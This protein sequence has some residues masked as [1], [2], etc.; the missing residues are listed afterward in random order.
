MCNTYYLTLFAAVL[1]MAC[2]VPTIGAASK[3]PP[4]A[5]GPQ[6]FAQVAQPFVEHNC[7]TCHG[8]KKAKAGFRI[9]L[10]GADFSAPKAAEQWKEVIDRINAGEM[11]PDGKT[12]PDARQSAAFVGWVNGQLHEVDLAAKKTGLRIVMRRLNRDEYANTVSDLLQIDEKIIAPIAEELPGDGKAEGFDRLGVALYFDQAQI[13]RSMAAAEKIA[14][15]AIVTEPP[16]INHYVTHFELQKK[17]PPPEMIPAYE[18]SKHLIPTGARDHFVRPDVIEHIQGYPTWRKEYDGWGSIDHFAIGG[19]VKRDGYYRVRIKAKVDNRGRTTPNKLRIQYAIDSPIYAEKEIL[20]DPSGTTETLVFLRGPDASGEVKGPQVFTLLWNHTEKVVIMEPN[21]AKVFWEKNR[22]AS[23]LERAS[24]RRAPEAEMDALRKKRDEAV[25]ILDSWTGPAHA[26][27][28]A[29]DV[30]KLPRLLIESI[31]IEGPIEK[32]WPPP[33]HKA[34]FFAGDDRKDIGYAREIF[35]RFLPRAYR[36]PVTTDE[37]EGIVSVVNDAM[38]AGKL[39]FTEAMRLGLQRV[40]CAPGFLFLQ[41]PAAQMQRRS[42]NDYELAS[43]LSYFLWST[44][45]DEALFALA[46]AGK[47][48][49][50]GVLK[51]E[52]QRMLAHPKSDHFVRN[53]AGQWLSVRDFAS[54]QPAAEYQNFDKLLEAAERQEPYEFFNEVLSKNLPITSFL[55][56]DFL[57]I[58]D[59]LA[60]HYGIAGVPG[61]EFRR[62]AIRPENHRGGVLGMAGLMTWLADGT[63]TLPMH[64]ANWVLRELFNDPPNNPPPNAGEIQPNTSGKN[65]TV[66]QRLELHR[67]DEICASCHFKLD[68][69]GLALENYD[70]IGEWREHFNGEGFRGNKAPALDVSGTFPD[71]RKFTTLE[72]YKAGLMAQKDKFARAFS[73]KLLTYALGRAVGYTDRETVDG[74]VETLKKNDYRIQSVIEAIVMSEPFRTK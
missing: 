8:P 67:H 43:R 1:A 44:M 31:E 34:L 50:P 7:M 30:E 66:R 64:R 10:I 74:L 17:R 62:V 22:L 68:P 60:K 15:L 18:F 39:S 3:E 6:G 58:N 40:L 72:E 45:P 35:A 13:E 23:E 47:L 36:R 51:T 20:V 70:A 61:A 12:R 32:E 55:D 54:V 41:E 57:I 2:V 69:Y 25:Q 37:I 59:R 4:A 27:N 21:Y 5:P 38:T 28:P 52:I 63:R 71:G 48:H 29:L 56:S 19:V 14:P 9:D 42:L 33:G 49:E 26:Y 11:P 53:F 46:A 16:K 73:T 24:T 65:L